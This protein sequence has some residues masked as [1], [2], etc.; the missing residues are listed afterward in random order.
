M[1][2]TQALYG[3]DL[4]RL[5]PFA[6]SLA[7]KG[8]LKWA[9]AITASLGAI[10]EVIDTSIVNVALPDIQGNLG[11][12]LSEAGWVSTG[13]ACANVVI[14]P[15]TAWLGYRFG[16]KNYLLFSLIGFTV[17]SFLCGLAPN[18][19]FL[20]FARVLQGLAGGGLLAKAQAIRHR[21]HRRP[22][23]RSGDRRLPDRH[24]RLALD[25]L[26]QPAGGHHRRAHGNG[27]PARGPRGRDRPHA[28]GLARAR[29]AHDGPRLPANLP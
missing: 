24:A 2:E 18:L 14:I 27:L 25:F 11:A 7:R 12:T 23:L 19:P 3:S 22:R 9:I 13:Y 6:A 5:S 10:L 26:H 8:T 20:V 4:S 29:A 1:P 21:R 28:R 16:K 17:A 15:L